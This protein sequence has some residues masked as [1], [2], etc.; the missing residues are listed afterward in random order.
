MKIPMLDLKA[1]YESIKEEIDRKV[2]EI[3][4]SQV[5]IL[6]PEV[7]A[8]EKELAAYCGTQYAVG[9]SSGSDALLLSLMALGVGTGDAV[10][11]TPFTFFATAGAITRLGARPVFCD[12]Q[13][14]TCNLDPQCLAD[15]LEMEKGKGDLNLK[16]IIPVHLYG[17]C[18]DMASINELASQYGLSVIEDAAQAVGAEYPLEGLVKR[19]CSL[20]DMGSLSFFPAK[21]LGGFGD[22]GMVL[23]D[24]EDLFNKLKLMRTHGS[25]NKYFYDV[26]GGNFRLDAL[27][28][29]ILRVKL[30]HLD[31]WHLGRMRNAARYDRLLVES[32]LVEKKSVLT[33]AAVYKNDGVRNYHIYNQYV[34]RV[35]RRDE[36][37]DFLDSKGIPTAIYYPLPLHMQNCFSDLGYTQGAF[38]V[39][40]K[41]AGEVLALPVFPE[42]KEEQQNYIVST[43]QEFFNV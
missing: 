34:I 10:I 7:A 13:E 24:N 28:A 37:K 15:I 16:A 4:S 39:S 12:I 31:R 18:V 41:A 27:Q 43:I 3:L 42:L 22:G 2:L 33:P 11:T 23:T 21:N 1:Q 25:R 32:G 5:F 38:P 20:G 14:Q 30:K 40:E 35:P 36:L 26:V 8:L 19:A 17:Q 9:V 6:G 29:G